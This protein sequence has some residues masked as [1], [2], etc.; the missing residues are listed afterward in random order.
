MKELRLNLP[1][2]AKIAGANGGKEGKEGNGNDAGGSAGRH[3]KA[4]RRA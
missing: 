3:Q 2:S 1:N 4:G